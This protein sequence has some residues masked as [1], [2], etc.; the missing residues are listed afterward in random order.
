M[1][2]RLPH[3]NTDKHSPENIEKVGHAAN[4]VLMRVRE[5]AQDR[6]HAAA[7]ILVNGCLGLKNG[8]PDVIQVPA[9]H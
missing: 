3:G 2:G 1:I 5:T 7:A 9:H 4:I 8:D 6:L